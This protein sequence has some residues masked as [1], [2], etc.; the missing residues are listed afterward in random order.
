M[1]K[2]G[3]HASFSKPMRRVKVNFMFPVHEMFTAYAHPGI[4]ARPLFIPRR[5]FI[6]FAINQVYKVMVESH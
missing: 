1:K 3:A 5:F 4:Q 2:F 6:A